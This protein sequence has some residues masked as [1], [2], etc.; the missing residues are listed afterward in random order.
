MIKSAVAHDLVVS[1]IDTVSS[2]DSYYIN[3]KVVCTYFWH[4][5]RVD[6]FVADCNL[7][8]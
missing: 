4:F 7:I 5:N 8:L 3:I 6:M 1:Q 2:K